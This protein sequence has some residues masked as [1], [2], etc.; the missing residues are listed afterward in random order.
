MSYSRSQTNPV[1]KRTRN[2]DDIKRV[3]KLE[4]IR[5]HLRWAATLPDA[6]SLSPTNQW[7]NPVRL[8][9]KIEALAEAL[10]AVLWFW[11]CSLETILS[12]QIMSQSPNELP[13]EA[14]RVGRL[15]VRPPQCEIGMWIVEQSNIL[16]INNNHKYNT[17]YSCRN[18]C[19][20]GKYW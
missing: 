4:N 9:V 5:I 15:A 18:F 13:D 2:G 10:E 3:I 20:V 8:I 17:N 19:D 14:R 11:G 7:L 12:F 6:I 16:K 1:L